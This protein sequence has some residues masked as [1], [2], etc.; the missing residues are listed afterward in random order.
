MKKLQKSLC[1]FALVIASL[2]LMG[3]KEIPTEAVPS[4]RALY[5]VKAFGAK[6]NYLSDDTVP[7]Q[8]AINDAC[9]AAVGN[10]PA[11]IPTVYLSHGAYRHSFPW[12]ISCQNAIRITGDGDQGTSVTGPVNGGLFP[13]FFFAPANYVAKLG[14]R[15]APS[16]AAGGGHALSWDAGQDYFYSFKDAQGGSSENGPWNNGHPLNGLGAFSFE[17]YAD[18]TAQKPGS[19]YIA[20]SI[21]NDNN[22]NTFGALD[23]DISH[24]SP[25]SI[26]FCL[27]VSNS[28][29]KCA[30]GRLTN[31]ATHFIEGN[32]DGSYVRLFIDGA[33]AQASAA[34][35][36]IVQKASESFTLGTQSGGPFEASGFGSHFVGRM[37]SIRLSNVARHT[38][39]YSVPSAKLSRDGNTMFLVNGTG[40]QDAFLKV[41]ATYGGGPTTWI[42]A[43]NA[44]LTGFIERYRIENLATTGGSYGVL[45]IE[46][47]VGSAN[48]LFLSGA[49]VAGFRKWNNC[50]SW[51]ENNLHIRSANYGE[52]NY[53]A[54]YLSGLTTST[55]MNVSGGYY[56]IVLIDG[57]GV[58]NNTYILSSN[59]TQV[60]IFAEG[61]TTDNEEYLFNAP[62]FDTENGGT[63][64]PIRLSGQGSYTIVN[65]DLQTNGAVA[66]LSCLNLNPV[67]MSSVTLINSR[68]SMS[69]KA[70]NIVNVTNP[71]QGGLLQ[72]V[73]F[74]NFV[75]NNTPLGRTS[76]PIS[77]EMKDVSIIGDVWAPPRSSFKDLGSPRDGS[78][79]FCPDC[80]MTN[81]CT[82]SGSGAFAKR[83]NG[84]WVCN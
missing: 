78:M 55:H 45:V 17:L 52:T 51:S 6:G 61:A 40:F 26:E 31:D 64:V 75:A 38:S 80:R 59:I 3:Q 68:C 83:I 20:S 19:Y 77:N 34:S 79:K 12:V 43:Y 42:P 57:H 44:I 48:N 70:L 4:G 15:S 8:N 82:A 54:S 35:G 76:I 41:D 69:P 13:H 47:Q 23:F 53:E 25:S 67:N 2:A 1:Y 33:L 14:E 10:S 36:S 11:V 73:L 7:V 5:D 46:S 24:G 22:V 84:S 30:R 56:S 37:D 66:G 32:F 9:R 29:R 28:G 21:G 27:T 58:F 72:P 62:D 81:P 71:G 49:S 65:G 16:I 39:S 50:W 63:M 74:V 18:F 60:G